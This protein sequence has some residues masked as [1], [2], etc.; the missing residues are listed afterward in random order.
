MDDEN[1]SLCLAVV[2]VGTELKKRLPAQVSQ[3][4]M[5]T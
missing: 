1:A 2:L 5:E 3:A 4:L